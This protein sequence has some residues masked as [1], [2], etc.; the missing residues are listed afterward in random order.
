MGSLRLRQHKSSVRVSNKFQEVTRHFYGLSPGFRPFFELLYVIQ[1]LQSHFSA[2]EELKYSWAAPPCLCAY[3]NVPSGTWPGAHWSMGQ[4]Q[5]YGTFHRFG[6]ACPSIASSHPSQGIHPWLSPCSSHPVLWERGLWCPDTNS[7]EGWC[8]GDAL[9][10]SG[11]T[12]RSHWVAPTPRGTDP[13]WG[14]SHLCIQGRLH[15]AG[16][17]PPCPGT[18]RE[19]ERKA[20]TL[21]PPPR[22]CKTQLAP[23]PVNW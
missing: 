23:D 17:V 14:S 2:R 15:T 1:Y 6:A 19:C 4:G 13:L 16:P 12:G 8:W 22:G 5:V 3:T 20:G 7:L 18:A 9:P 11:S 10:E 21:S